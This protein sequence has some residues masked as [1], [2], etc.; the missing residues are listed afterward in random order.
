MLFSEELE[1]G[2]QVNGRDKQKSR[3][4][5]KKDACWYGKCLGDV[6]QNGG[7]LAFSAG[8]GLYM[9]VA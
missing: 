7:R 8:T 2:V 6:G 5:T 9:C 4:G 3:L 1:M